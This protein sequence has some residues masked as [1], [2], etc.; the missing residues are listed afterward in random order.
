MTS[1]ESDL[2]VPHPYGDL[3]LLFVRESVVHLQS[4]QI[5]LAQRNGA[6]WNRFNSSKAK[7]NNLDKQESALTEKFNEIS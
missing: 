4:T 2:F 1:S 7:Y 5:N 6:H 3:N